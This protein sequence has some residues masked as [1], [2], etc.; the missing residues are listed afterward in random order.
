M[1]LSKIFSVG[2]V[3]I[4][5]EFLVE[6]HVNGGPPKYECEVCEAKFD[7]NMK[8]PHLTGVKHR[9]TVIVSKKENRKRNSVIFLIY[10]CFSSYLLD[11]TLS[12]FLKVST[13]MYLYML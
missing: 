10:F 1:L 8:F 7:G 6:I 9:H 2:I 12:S 4:G 3:W 13:V 11:S 5:L